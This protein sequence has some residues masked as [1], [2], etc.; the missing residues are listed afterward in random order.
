MSKDYLSSIK[1]SSDFSISGISDAISAAFGNPMP[2]TKPNTTGT[3]SKKRFTNLK[4][5]TIGK[6]T[7]LTEAEMNEIEE[8]MSIE[9]KTAM[10]YEEMIKEVDDITSGMR[11]RDDDLSELKRRLE[12]C[13]EGIDIQ[14]AQFQGL[15]R[16]AKEIHSQNKVLMKKFKSMSTLPRYNE[17][18]NK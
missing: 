16:S 18:S 6:E 13:K 3:S 2:P 5:K 17:N 9:G 8:Q 7:F 14:E 10:S 11:S 1:F 15:D 12:R 4:T